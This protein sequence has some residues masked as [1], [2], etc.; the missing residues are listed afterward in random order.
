MTAETAPQAGGK[1]RGGGAFYCVSDA[2]YFL[3]AVAMINSL[4]LLGH[5]DPIYLLDLGLSEEQREQ[6]SPEVT[7]VAPDEEAPPWLLK[8]VAPLAHPAEVMVLIDVDMIATRPLTELIRSASSG[9]VLAFENE[10]DR[11]LPEWG[12][13]L[14]LGQVRRQPYL[15]S[16]LVVAGGGTGSEVIAL[17]DDRQRRVDFER[18]FYGRNDPAYPFVYPEQDVLN[19]ILASRVEPERVVA[20]DYRLAP[21]PPFS[22]LRVID[23]DALR[24]AYADGTSPYVVHHFGVKPWLEPTHHGVYS[25]L[26]RRLLIGSDLAI[27]IPPEGLPLRFR[28]GPFAYAERKRVNLGQRLR[29][30]VGEPLSARVQE[31]AGRRRTP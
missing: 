18:T 26:L 25:R 21:M 30:H 28:N 17:L 23:E 22:G 16:G 3:G 8:T 29:W 5:R 4:R 1:P 2:R 6:L 24:C 13:L 27:R 11:H 12:E 14:Q 20:L 10:T 31:L 15:C 19:A 7:F 9:R